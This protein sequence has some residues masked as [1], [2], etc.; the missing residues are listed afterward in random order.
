MAELRCG[1]SISHTF[2]LDNYAY[3]FRHHCVLPLWNQ[4][5]AKI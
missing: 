3:M 5:A 4:G 1:I 2:D